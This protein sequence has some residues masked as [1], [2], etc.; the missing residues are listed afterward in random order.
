MS[1][2]TELCRGHESLLHWCVKRGNSNQV[3]QPLYTCGAHVQER[4][5]GPACYLAHQAHHGC[6]LFTERHS[7]LGRW[8]CHNEI[9]ARSCPPV[10]KLH[11]SCLHIDC[12]IGKAHSEI[13]SLSL[14]LFLS[15]LPQAGLM[16]VLLAASHMVIGPDNLDNLRLFRLLQIRIQI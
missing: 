7:I 1:L 5:W 11:T 13:L 16:H 14:S 3:R 10:L 2:R 4:G 8:F 15:L 12:V 9:S 6:I